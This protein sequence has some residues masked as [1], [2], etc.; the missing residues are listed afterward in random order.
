M[1]KNTPSIIDLSLHTFSG[2]IFV[3]GRIS[4]REC[5]P[6]GHI[7]SL[8]LIEGYCIPCVRYKKYKG[9]K[10]ECR[11]HCFGDGLDGMTPRRQSQV[12]YLRRIYKY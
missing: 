6:C 4:C 10:A 11:L 8:C 9:P 3:R 2:T 1:S 5:E 12:P 7:P